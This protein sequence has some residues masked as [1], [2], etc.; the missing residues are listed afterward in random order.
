MDSWRSVPVLMYFFDVLCTN[1]LRDYIIKSQD[2]GLA[3]EKLFWIKRHYILI[4]KFDTQRASDWPN[5]NVSQDFFLFQIKGD[6]SP[7]KSCDIIVNTYAKTTGIVLPDDTNIIFFIRLTIRYEIRAILFMNTIYFLGR[8][9]FLV[10][11]MYRFL[12]FVPFVLSSSQE[13]RN[14]L[15]NFKSNFQYCFS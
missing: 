2:V 6:Q 10:E 11:I 9:Y 7:H 8:Y 5:P 14:S 3:C 1:E 12:K 4:K 15:I 13:N